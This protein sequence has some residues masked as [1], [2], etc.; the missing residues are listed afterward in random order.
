MY[1]IIIFETCSVHSAVIRGG[2]QGFR[3]PAL[4]YETGCNFKL[5]KKKKIRKVSYAISRVTVLELK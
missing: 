1:D 3:N 2:L 5:A 4:G